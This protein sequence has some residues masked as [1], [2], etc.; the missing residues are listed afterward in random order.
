[1][2][3]TKDLHLGCIKKEHNSELGM[4]AHT[5]NPSTWEATECSYTLN[6]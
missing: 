5:L 4:V 1:M 2:Y 3:L 6:K